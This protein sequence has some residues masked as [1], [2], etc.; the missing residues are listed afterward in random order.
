MADGP[1]LSK[2]LLG[3]P[4]FA[5]SLH[6]NHN[7]PWTA[8]NYKH[9]WCVNSHASSSSSA[10]PS[11]F[12]SHDLH[13]YAA[14]HKFAQIRHGFPNSNLR[15]ARQGPQDIYMIEGFH[16]SVIVLFVYESVSTFLDECIHMNMLRQVRETCQ[17]SSENW[18]RS[19]TH[20][21]W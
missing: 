7:H 1:S 19:R 14:S 15:A 13:H 6:W 4:L 2:H 18:S 20:I 10:Y 3:N 8:H 16:H 12:D 5:I 9:S 11:R 21:F 17:V